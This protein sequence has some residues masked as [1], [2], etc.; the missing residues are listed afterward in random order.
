MRAPVLLTI[1]GVTMSMAEWS[2]KPGAAKYAT[3][4]RRL[5]V[6]GYDDAR[7]VFGEAQVGGQMRGQTY[8]AGHYKPRSRP[9]AVVMAPAPHVP[10]PLPP[11]FGG[12]RSWPI[13]A[14]ELLRRVA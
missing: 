6:Y 4:C 10:N 9:R 12:F 3:I 5:R 8:P 2:R 14:L 13:E 1:H 7:A 11:R